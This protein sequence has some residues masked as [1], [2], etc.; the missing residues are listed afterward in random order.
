VLNVL[1]TP[2][3]ELGR[4]VVR[5]LLAISAKG[6]HTTT[7][8]IR[9]MASS[10]SERVREELVAR[11]V[12][13]APLSWNDP[14]AMQLTLKDIHKVLFLPGY[15]SSALSWASSLAEATKSQPTKLSHFLRVGISGMNESTTLGKWGK[16]INELFE[17]HDIPTA[18]VNVN[19]LYQELLAG[20]Q[21]K[22]T[23]TISASYMIP[24]EL[25]DTSMAPIDARDVAVLM[26]NIIMSESGNLGA[27][28]S[29]EI[30]VNGPT[31]MT[32]R[33]MGEVVG[34][35]LGMETGGE[36][37][38]GMAGIGVGIG[39]ME[40]LEEVLRVYKKGGAKEVNEKAVERIELIL[41]RKMFTFENYLEEYVQRKGGR[42]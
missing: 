37:S 3:G 13:V 1:V 16:A 32:F 6:Y 20:T 9:I 5:E 22:R 36:E 27:R 25:Q 30:V 8:K 11:Q 38:F 26:A 35:A 23:S 4:E 15:S 29:S 7:L 24:P 28:K 10:V 12:E 2:W 21:G 34:R 17:A 42:N 18:T 39:N 41:G 19:Q 40:V 31:S 33:R 14:K